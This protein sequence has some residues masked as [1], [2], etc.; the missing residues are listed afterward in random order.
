MRARWEIALGLFAAAVGGLAWAFPDAHPLAVVFCLLCAILTIYLYRHQLGRIPFWL[1]RRH[2]QFHKDFVTLSGDVIIA[3][4]VPV[5]LVA[6]PIYAV[7]WIFY[8]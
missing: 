3:V 4:I 8:G 6:V 5:M 2:A 1:L 7:S